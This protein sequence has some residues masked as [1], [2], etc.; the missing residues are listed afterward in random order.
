MALHGGDETAIPLQ[1]PVRMDHGQA[2]TDAG[3]LGQSF[4]VLA[5]PPASGGTMDGVTTPGREG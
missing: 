2:Y 3:S 1:Q 4:V 5:K